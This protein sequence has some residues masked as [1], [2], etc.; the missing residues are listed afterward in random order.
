MFDG[1][2]LTVSNGATF[3]IDTLLGN[4]NSAAPL[5]TV[6]LNGGTLYFGFGGQFGFTLYL[7]RLVTGTS[8]GLVQFNP[9]RGGDLVFTGTGAGAGKGGTY[10]HSG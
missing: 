6:T 1:A 10:G 4:N 9:V 8:G 5:R 3:L 2:S 7:N